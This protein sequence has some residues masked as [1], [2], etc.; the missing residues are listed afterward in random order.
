MSTFQS[1]ILLLIPNLG[2]GGAQRVFHDHSI[3][4]SKCYCVTEVVFNL[5]SSNVYA[6][7]DKVKSLD[8]AG[9]GNTLEKLRNFYRRVERLKKLKRE[10]AIE[11]SISHLEGADYVNLLSKGTGKI[12]L[13]VHGSKLHDRNISGGLGWLRRQLFI[14]WLYRRATA[15]VAVS[16]GIRDELVKDL[17]LPANKVN[18]INNFFD[19]DAINQQAANEPPRPY[20]EV[21]ANCPVIATAGRFAPEKN[22]LALLEVFALVRQRLPRCKLMLIGQGEQY[23]ALLDRCQSLDLSVYLPEHSPEQAQNAAVLFTGFQ[24]N[25]H[26]FITRATLFVLPSLNEGFPMALG[27][28]MVCGRPVAAADCPTGPREMLAPGTNNPFP[29]LRNAE[30]AAYGVLLPIISDPSTYLADISVWSESLIRLLENSDERERLSQKARERMQDFS[31]QRI[32]NQ[33]L[34][35]VEKVRQN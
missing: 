6:S 19:T 27:E 12:I 8:V 14:P 11:I 16:S 5:D 24:S 17:G 29:S 31:R 28:A 3:E 33:W 21:L 4:L 30:Q 18:V 26:V 32:A 2:L 20:L 25:P 34:Q 7:Q 10:L 13:C 22:L 35:L 15:I 1:R 23:Q 9:G